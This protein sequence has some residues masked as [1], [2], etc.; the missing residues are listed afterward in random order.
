MF[1][2]CNKYMEI[3][4]KLHTSSF[5][6]ATNN[7]SVQT[8][9]ILPLKKTNYEHKNMA[10]EQICMKDNFQ[11]QDSQ[12]NYWDHSSSIISF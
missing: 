1:K 5:D 6:E 11:R 10:H 8:K 12:H 3:N 4:L 7:I 2:T 9:R